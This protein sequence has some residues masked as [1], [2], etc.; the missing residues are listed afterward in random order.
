[1]KTEWGKWGA[2]ARPIDPHYLDGAPGS[3]EAAL[4]LDLR[5]GRR[6]RPGCHERMAERLGVDPDTIYKFTSRLDRR[7]TTEHLEAVVEATG[8]GHALAYLRRLAGGREL[9]RITGSTGS[10]EKKGESGLGAAVAEVLERLAAINR[11]V[12]EDLDEGDDTPRRIDAGEGRRLG[13]M[14]EQA[15]AELAV[16]RAR[17]EAAG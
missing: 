13:A 14:L 11:Q 12:A 15:E 10:G 5:E 1:M 8:G 16:L 9:D 17:V 7:W 4:R 2:G 6:R 3:L